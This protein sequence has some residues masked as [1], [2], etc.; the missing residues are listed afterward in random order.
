MRR[1][2]CARIREAVTAELVR[3]NREIGPDVLSAL[4]SGL[5][6]EESPVGRSVLGQ[7]IENDHIAAREG[8]A[9]CQD[10]GMVVAFVTL[11][12]E[13]HLTGGSFREALDG[14]VRDAYREARLRNSVVRDPLFDRSN[15]GDNTP[16][17]LH[18]DLV[19]GDGLTIDLMAKGFGSENMSALAML[20]PAEGEEGVRRL[21]VDTVRK[22][23]P[24]PCPP[25]IVGVGL[26]GTF[27]QAALLSKK[28]LFRP[29]GEPSPD[30]RYAAL[31]ASLLADINRLGI[32]P[33]GLG[34]RITSLAVH[35]ETG[36]T[37]IAS[38][39]AAVNI[40]CHASRHGRV[41]L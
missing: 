5:R 29:L 3:I 26:G 39:P 22:A 6:T 40:S 23:G 18:L 8:R 21:V 20:S 15:T 19:P 10:T 33:A 41:I 37:H 2:D 17:V 32:G 4:E 35:I 25:V 30:P 28:A 7:L 14:A 9:I 16:A 12:Q 31:E 24:N 13:V 1:I 34:G 36:P 38:I 11:G 27:E